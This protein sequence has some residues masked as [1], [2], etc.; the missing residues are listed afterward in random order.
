MSGAN[1]LAFE[2]QRNNGSDTWGLRVTAVI[3]LN[4][5]SWFEPLKGLANAFSVGVGAVLKK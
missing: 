2:Y 3:W 5:E 4:G 1:R